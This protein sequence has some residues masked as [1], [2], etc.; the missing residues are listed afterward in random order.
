M[1]IYARRR[2][3]TFSGKQVTI[4]A[5]VKDGLFGA[6]KRHTF[7]VSRISDVSNTEPRAFSPGC[8]KFKVTGASTAVIEN[9]ASGGDKADM[10]TFYYSSSDRK[11]V[12]QLVEAIKAAMP[13]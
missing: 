10:C 6:D 3:L 1:Y 4:K 9:P 11:K 13:K 2:S 7:T 5:A 8:L 12:R